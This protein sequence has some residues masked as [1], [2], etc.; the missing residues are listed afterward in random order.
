MVNGKAHPYI[1]NSEESIKKEML[2][3]LGM[4]S[5]EDIFEAIPERL[6]FRGKMKLPEPILSE[7]RLRR[8]VEEM[9]KKNR[10]CRD[11]ISFLGGGCWQHYVPSVCD[12]I[13]VRDEFLTAYVG[14][15][16]SDHGKFQALFET[17][18][19]IADLAGFEACNTPTYD[20]A[21]AVAVA[22]RMACR[23][24]GRRRILVGEDMSPGRLLVVQNYW[25]PEIEL[26]RVKYDYQNGG[27]DLNDLKSK[28][29]KDTTAVYFENPSYLGFI[30]TRV[31]EI[32]KVAHDAGAFVI[33]GADPTSLGVLEGPGNCGADYA[34]GDFQPLGLH[35]GFGGNQSG[36]IATSDDKDMLAEYPSL[37]YG[38]TETT[39]EGE[40]GFGEVFYERTSYASREKGKDFVGTTTALYGIVAGV[41]MALMGP[42]G[43][44][45]LGEGIMQRVEYAKRKIAGIPKV[46]IASPQAYT[47][48]EFIVDFNGT[49]KTVREINKALLSA[50]I[51]GGKDI[52]REFPIFG[53]SA[54]YC[55]T[56]MHTK[57]DI[58]KLVTA[59]AG[60]CAV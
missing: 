3:E 9:L 8:H 1:P 22:G 53:Q 14:E 17:A 28:I 24:K 32:V 29:T 43:F 34:V 12:T 16:Y 18:S 56:E 23:T 35:I 11:N 20:W 46:K 26:V 60:I 37:L 52:S 59:F 10:N 6:R 39:R 58:D 38:I 51:F 4:K 33:V 40:W 7:A 31:K 55:V 5:A 42:Q 57:E 54:L 15:A 19:M 27:M 2:K 13:A 41:Y 30:E 36:W 25:K 47:F 50:N 44:R 21:F 45:E 48:K 49:G